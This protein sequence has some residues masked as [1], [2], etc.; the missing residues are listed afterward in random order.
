MTARDVIAPSA[1]GLP[2]WVVHRVRTARAAVRAGASDGSDVVTQIARR[3]G[4]T[5]RL[6]VLALAQLQA[7]DNPRGHGPNGPA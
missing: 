2:G 6:A 4:V 1:S 3:A 7:E 5:R